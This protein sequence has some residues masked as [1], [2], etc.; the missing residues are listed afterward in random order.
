MIFRLFNFFK[1]NNIAFCI[2]NGYKDI[3][4]QIDTE[5]DIDIL[6]KLES[7]SHIED[8]LKKFCIEENLKIV[9]ALHHD[10]WAKNIFLFNPIDGQYLNLDLYGELSRKE[11][12]FFEEIDIFNTLGVYEGIP[13]L[14][15]E[16]EFINYLI[17]KLDKDDLS[18]E[19]FMH[20]KSLY[21]RDELKCTEHLTKLFPQ[22]YK[23]LVDAFKNDS[24]QLIKQTRDEIVL[25]FYNNI[26]V[27]KKRSLLNLKRTIKRVI[28]PTGL[29]ISFLGP[30]GSGKSTI[31][32]TLLE[33]RLPFR[34]DDYFHLKPVITKKV[35]LQ[36]EM[37]TDPH[38]H[39][40]YSPPK[41][42]IKLLYFL[43]Q[44]NVGWL[45]NIS[46]IK[47]KSSLIIFDRYFDDMLVDYKR[48]RYGG[49]LKVAKFAR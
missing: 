23:L 42:Y 17:K 46:N 34:R 41:S 5:S 21:I 9:Q 8:I 18:K 28:K 22:K 30:D 26:K 6:L 13:I 20:L 3:L 4:E 12:V 39:V 47:I 10:L 2:I 14:S 48:Y 1:N 40:P 38:K 25:D 44:Y 19:N 27:N 31:I 33:K 49:S 16:K 29:T 35:S 43:Y 32:D 7:F 15:S 36:D 24:F 37:V 45:K 11:K